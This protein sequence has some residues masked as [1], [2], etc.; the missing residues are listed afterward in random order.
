M[1]DQPRG[2]VILLYQR[3][4]ERQDR[5]WPGQW[6][7]G[8]TENGKKLAILVEEVGET[9]TALQDHDGRDS[10]DL[11]EELLHV[12]SV[13]GAWLESIIGDKEYLQRQTRLEETRR[14]LLN[15][16]TT[17]ALTDHERRVSTEEETLELGR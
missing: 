7:K 8:N 10:D 16:T 17:G 13:A 6:E 3:E 2:T 5:M 12:M 14:N 15:R 4:R 11:L 9:G 1:S